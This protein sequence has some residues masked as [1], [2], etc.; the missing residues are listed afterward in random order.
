MIRVCAVCNFDLQ[1]SSGNNIGDCNG[2]VIAGDTL[3]NIFGPFLNKV[4]E[5]CGKCVL[6]SERVFARETSPTTSDELI[7][8]LKDERTKIRANRQVF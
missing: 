6:L 8:A 1:P 2:F 3:P 5:V 7:E 4:R